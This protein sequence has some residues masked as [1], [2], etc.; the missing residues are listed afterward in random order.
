MASRKN[1]H[2]SNNL[3]RIKIDPWTG[4]KFS[5][6]VDIVAATACVAAPATIH[7]HSRT[8]IHTFHPM[9]GVL[10]FCTVHYVIVDQ[11]N[12]SLLNLL[13]IPP[14]AEVGLTRDDCWMV[15]TFWVH[16]C[17]SYSD[18]IY[19]HALLTYCEASRKA[20]GLSELRS[21][22]KWGSMT[23]R[24]SEARQHSDSAREFIHNARSI[25]HVIISSNESS[26]VI[27][28]HCRPIKSVFTQTTSKTGY[29]CVI[30]KSFGV[31]VCISR[32]MPFRASLTMRKLGFEVECVK[33]YLVGLM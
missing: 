13:R 9:R 21:L 7:F 24:A 5:Y 8:F 16:V 27:S 15:T 20:C 17:I 18:V 14:R 3:N 10:V 11:W 30:I 23:L 22:I 4:E 26:F 12:R 32:P 1:S 29:A 2:G 33:K 6:N 25:E 31:P 19:T 28:R